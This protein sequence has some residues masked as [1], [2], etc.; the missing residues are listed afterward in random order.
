MYTIIPKGI[1]GGFEDDIQ[2]SPKGEV[3]SSGYIPRHKALRYIHVSSTM[4]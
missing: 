2:L 4:N 1:V 3:N